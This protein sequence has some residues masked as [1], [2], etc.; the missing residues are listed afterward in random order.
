MLKWVDW[1]NHRRPFEPNGDMP[2]AE[3]EQ[4]YDQNQR[5]AKVA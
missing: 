2:L 4:M 1:F 5:W 3:K